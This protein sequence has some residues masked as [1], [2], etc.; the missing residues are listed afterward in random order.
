V[1]AL[2]K[3][4]ATEARKGLVGR[5]NAAGGINPP[6]TLKCTTTVEDLEAK[7]QSQLDGSGVIGARDLAKVTSP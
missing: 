2:M 7:L 3:V 1:L 4:D 5:K 6:A